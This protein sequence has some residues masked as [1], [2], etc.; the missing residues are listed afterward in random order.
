MKLIYAIVN[1][2]DSPRLMAE[3]NRQGN[4][5]TKLASSGGFLRSGNTTLMTVVTDDQL[6]G[7]LD[8]IR[9]YSKSRKAAINANVAPTSMGGN[10]M[11]Y[12]VEV[13]VGGATVFVVNVEHFEKI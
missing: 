7:V 6:E 5:V 13:Q 10:Y 3:I 12:P 11:P 4:R 2:E 8:I 9:K 1:D